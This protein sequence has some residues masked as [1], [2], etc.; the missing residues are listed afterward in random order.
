NTALSEEA[1][2]RYETVESQL[3]T[4]K[5]EVVDIAIEFGGPFL[6]ALRDG[7][8][9]AKPLLQTVGDLAKK[10]SQANPETQQAIMKYLGLAAAIGP[11][12]KVMGGFLKIAGGGIST[13][14]KFSQWI[15][16]LSGNAKASEV[17]L[18]IAEDGTVKVV[19]AMSTGTQSVGL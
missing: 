13:I 3:S 4:L 9:A 14:G 16:K 12:S 7:I 17:A 19:N 2:K 10:F 1:G 5:N 8:Q 6:Q 15:G 11:V 18:K